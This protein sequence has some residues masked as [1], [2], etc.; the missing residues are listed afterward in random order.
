MNWGD[1]QL[2]LHG[3]TGTSIAVTPKSKDAMPRQRFRKE[4][5]R[6]G[7]YVKSTDAKLK[8][9]F[10]ITPEMLLH[11]VT[12]FDAMKKDGIEVP[13][14]KDHSM[15][16]EDSLGNVEEMFIEGGS[17]FGILEMIGEDAI[18]AAHRNNVS[19]FSPTDWTD[20]NGKKWEHPIRH[21]GVTPYPVIP[22]LQK[23]EAIAASFVDEKETKMD[24]KKIKQALGIDKDVTEANAEELILSYATAKT[25]EFKTLSDSVAELKTKLEAAE[26]KMAGDTP[27][28]TIDP[29]M[30]SMA[31]ENREL[32][33][34]KLVEGGSITPAVAK[35][36][37]AAFAT[38]DTLTLSLTSG[39]DPFDKVIDALKENAALIELRKERSGPQLLELS[40]RVR[41]EGDKGKSVLE[42]QAEEMAKNAKSGTTNW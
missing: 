21:V 17:L 31:C 34:E 6:V 40:H 33:I 35:K 25:E 39:H 2:V 15:K 4:L 42:M 26:K 28:K 37:T 8:N 38:K 24:L 7:R 32:K 16:S 13:V 14:P 22:G 12:T 1:E 30:L 36:L 41:G 20:G 11:W 19:I 27:P 18:L 9:G 3:P 23:F 29:L 10:S 5:I